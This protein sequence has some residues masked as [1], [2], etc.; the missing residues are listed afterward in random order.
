MTQ[1]FSTLSAA[2]ENALL[3]ARTQRFRLPVLIEASC[4]SE[5]AALSPLL[6]QQTRLLAPSA[7]EVLP[8]T[9]PC[10]RRQ[11]QRELGQEID[12]LIIDLRVTDS[13]AIDVDA[14]GMASGMI[15]AGGLLILLT[16]DQPDGL[17]QNS[18]FLQRW[19]RLL[20]AMR[21]TFVR[22]E[23]GIW[24]LPEFL[25]HPAT[26]RERISDP[27]R[28]GDQARCVA[29]IVASAKGRA[30]RPLVI[31]ADRGR[32]KSHGLG[33]AIAQL[34]SEGALHSA[35]P[36]LLTAP[37]I[38]NV[39][40]VLN[41]VEA[42]EASSACR[43]V[44][45]DRLLE[46]LPD[47]PLLLID[48]AAAIPAHVLQ[49]LCAHYPRVVMATTV[50][51]YEGTGRG[52]AIRFRQHLKDN[53]PAWKHCSLTAPV[54]WQQGDPVEALTHQLLLLDAEPTRWP[55]PASQPQQRQAA[56]A[57]REE[58]DQEA[59]LR[60]IFGLLV[61]AHY[62]TTPRDLQ[63]LL[64]DPDT[65]ALGMPSSAHDSWAGCL[66]CRQEGPIEPALAEAIWRGERRPAGDLL[67]QAL[68]FQA[69][70]RDAASLRF[71]RVQR[72]AVREEAQRQGIGRAL[73]AAQ[74]QQGR[75]RG[76]DIIGTS[77]GLSLPLL[78]FWRAC[79]Y[80]L[81]SLGLRRD[82]TS[83]EFSALLLKPLNSAGTALVVE[84]RQH[85]L[86]ELPL[87][88][89]GPLKTME[90]ALACALLWQQALTPEPFCTKD[91]SDLDAFCQGNREL[92]R[93]R[94]ALDKLLLTAL[95]KG[96]DASMCEWLIAQLWQ[97][98]DEAL[99]AG[100]RKLSVGRP[101]QQALRAA[102]LKL[103]RHVGG[104]L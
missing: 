96:C 66:L 77:F 47:T 71:G 69:G 50:H 55:E 15:R 83:G 53:Y 74:E 99:L 45:V 4:L 97:Q 23:Q 19:Q 8:D 81:A 24:R 70:L 85:C 14:I 22:A 76:W 61:Q 30:R 11:L 17:T 34:A 3:V 95:K 86:K 49:Q 60:D 27:Y 46:T 80:Q 39:S 35:Q 33:L 98:Q 32:G 92:W 43:F 63:W 26:A 51:G 58:L 56:I 31:E 7:L 101:Y 13:S 2:L 89:S 54:R 52:F 21:T 90:P 20:H 72:I 9:L 10:T 64:D 41:T 29:Q 94:S 40:E 104:S 75:Q 84:A 6:G 67:P 62:R 16:P 73:L 91:N 25:S 87:M 48:E 1:G 38:T 82:S 78:A 88:L 68:L 28:T 57:L 103:W 36:A 59:V 79:G 18:R 12:S 100:V 102:V 37:A 44:P 5:L 42:Q 93:S 65:L